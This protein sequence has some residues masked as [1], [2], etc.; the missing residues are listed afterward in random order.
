MNSARMIAE[1]SADFSRWSKM[2]RDE[3]NAEYEKEVARMWKSLQPK[4]IN[5]FPANRLSALSE[6]SLDDER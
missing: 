1:A 5:A 4:A 6:T 3:L 2:S